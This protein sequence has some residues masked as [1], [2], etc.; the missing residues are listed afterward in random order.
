MMQPVKML[1]PYAPRVLSTAENAAIT[2]QCITSV[3]PDDEAR[4][5][6]D[7]PRKHDEDQPK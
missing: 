3:Y 5:P 2:R 6:A 7:F 1:H 4:W